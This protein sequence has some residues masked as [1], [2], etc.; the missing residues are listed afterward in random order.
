MWAAPDPADGNLI[1]TDLQDGRVN[2]FNRATQTSRGIAPY[3]DFSR[4]DF[5]ISQRKY[6]FNWDSPIASRR[7]TRKRYGTAEACCFRHKIAANTGRRSAQ[8]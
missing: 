6:R 1:Y 2:L 8:T 7:G 4:N 3:S 5:D